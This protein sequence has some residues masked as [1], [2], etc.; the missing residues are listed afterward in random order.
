MLTNLMKELFASVAGRLPFRKAKST[1]LTR[2]FHVA[3]EPGECFEL[4]P[5]SAGAVYTL[6]FMDEPGADGKTTLAGTPEFPL[7]VARLDNGSVMGQSFLAAD[8][9]DTTCVNFLTH[10]P[11][12]TDKIAIF[13]EPGRFQF[14]GSDLMRVAFDG[15]DHYGAGVLVG[16][17]E[18]FGHWL[19]NHLARLALSEAVPA[20]RGVPLVI[21]EDTP[22]SRLQCLERMGYGES[23]LIRLRRG[24]LARFERLWVPMMP[25]CGIDSRLFWSPDAVDFLRQRLGVQLT[26]GAGPRR[27][28]YLT[29]RGSRWRRLRNEE[30]VLA[31]LAAWG[32]EV[33]APET[34]SISRQ[35]EL[36]GESEVIAGPFGAGM[37]ML[38][39]APADAR[40]VELKYESGPIMDIHCVLAPHIGQ[41]YLPVLGTPIV[42]PGTA[43]ALNYDF[44][45]EPEAIERVLE[46]AGIPRR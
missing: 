29:R 5:M 11:R 8:R 20:T 45:V 3:R 28:L 18:N 13:E 35:I 44:T 33:I 12:S 22:A 7:R 43:N 31:R 26:A 39:F 30:A 40:I 34:L 15:M 16:N 10:N 42:E 25:F 9:N 23:S 14:V 38:L 6:R 2:T 1:A 46:S 4:E 41:R 32:F 36:A 21:G 27:R 37:I 24:R 17:H 19:L